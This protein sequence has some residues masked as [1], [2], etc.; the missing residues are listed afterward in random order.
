[1]SEDVKD[2]PSRPTLR[3]LEWVFFASGF[4][5]LLYQTIWQRT[6]FGI[7]GINIE[8]VTMIVTVFMVGL[9]VGS[10]VGGAISRSP[11]RPVALLF[12]GAETGIGLYGLVSP[13]I[14][15][16]VGEATVLASPLAIAGTT[17]AMLLVPTTLMGAT[18]PLLFA[19]F[20]RINKS[21]GDSM[22]ALYHMN[23]L[24][25]A[26]GALLGGIVMMAVLGQVGTL[27]AAAAL[28]FAAAAFALH[29]HRRQARV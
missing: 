5:A 28:N 9:G 25:A 4:A 16:W 3:I 20:A 24:G 23:T 14:F 18:L 15:H 22:G 13:S 7:Y 21:I 12:A 26:A 8:S 19:H 1:M 6:L 29:A 10:L 27:R 2:P 17:F 11:S